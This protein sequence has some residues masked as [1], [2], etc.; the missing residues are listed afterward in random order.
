LKG[1]Y[2][3]ELMVAS[4]VLYLMKCTHSGL[5]RDKGSETERERGRGTETG[6]VS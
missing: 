4:F 2:I 1:V 6:I 3:Y 5:K